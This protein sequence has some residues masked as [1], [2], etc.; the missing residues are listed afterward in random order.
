MPEAGWVGPGQIAYTHV[1]GYPTLE[2]VDLYTSTPTII[3]TWPT[4]SAATVLADATPC[5]TST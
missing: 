5:I 3:A 1:T 4:A 2:H